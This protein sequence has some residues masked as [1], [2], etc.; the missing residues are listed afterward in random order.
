MPKH[1]FILSYDADTRTVSSINIITIGNAPLPKY[2]R[3]GFL[4]SQNIL[5]KRSVVDSDYS[6]YFPASFFIAPKGRASYI[7]RMNFDYDAKHGKLKSLKL[8]NALA[9]GLIVLSQN[10]DRANGNNHYGG[11][12]GYRILGKNSG[13]FTPV[14]RYQEGKGLSV[15]LSLF[16]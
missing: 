4:E 9:I 11:G 13:S 6:V 16:F 7:I 3:Q 1:R 5:T 2:A 8:D 10:Y 12:V 14:L 15:D